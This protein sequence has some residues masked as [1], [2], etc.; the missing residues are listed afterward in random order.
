MNKKTIFSFRCVNK[1]RRNHAIEH[2]ALNILLT[3]RLWAV[4]IFGLGR[5]LGVGKSAH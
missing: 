4:R 3:Q 5:V 2:A 1:I